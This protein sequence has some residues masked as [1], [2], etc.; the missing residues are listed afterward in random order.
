MER[1]NMK[2]FD[3]DDFINI[4]FKVIGGVF[5]TICALAVIRVA[6]GVVGL[7]AGSFV[8][9]LILGLIGIHIFKKY[10]VKE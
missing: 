7:L 6:V 3:F 8:G 5:I 4:V 10:Y 9:C 1:I 2:N